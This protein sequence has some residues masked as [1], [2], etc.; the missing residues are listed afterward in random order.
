MWSRHCVCGPW[1]PEYWGID[2]LSDLFLALELFSLSV[3]QEPH[4]YIVHTFIFSKCEVWEYGCIYTLESKNYAATLTSWH[5]HVFSQHIHTHHTYFL[6]LPLLICLH[7]PGWLQVAKISTYIWMYKMVYC[8][9]FAMYSWGH[10]SPI[11]NCMF[12]KCGVCKHRRLGKTEKESKH[13]V[14]CHIHFLTHPQIH[15]THILYSRF[16]FACYRFGRL[17]VAIVF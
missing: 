11:I 2:T 10:N 1:T 17:E 12:S 15:H 13:Y 7:T 3:L 14:Y 9:D 8:T 6:A 5:T 16:W 4:F